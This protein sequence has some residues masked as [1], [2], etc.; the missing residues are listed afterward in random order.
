MENTPLN[1]L[2]SKNL[3]PSYY[4]DFQ[5]IGEK[6]RISCCKNW[7]ITFDKK[8]YLSLKKLKRSPELS[9]LMD[10]AMR[11]LR[12][13]DI[14][15]IHYAE[16]EL[17]DGICPL[18]A[19]S[20]LCNLQLEKGHK[21]LPE[22]C[23]IFPR[24]ERYYHSGYMQQS[25]SPACEAV[26][27]LLWNLPDGIEFR[28]SP[29][30]AD[31]IRN[32]SDQNPSPM[33]SHAYDIQSLC[34]D[35]LQDRRLPLPQRI[36]LM[37]ARLQELTKENTDIPAW[38]S[39]TRAI[40]S[41]SNV[42][43]QYK[44]LTVNDRSKIL[45]VSSCCKTLILIMNTESAFKNHFI[46]ILKSLNPDETENIS[47]NMSMYSQAESAFNEAF[48]NKEYFFENLTVSLMFH[49]KMP[50]LNSPEE[51]WKSYVNFCNLYSLYRFVSVLSA[52]TRLPPLPGESEDTAP[53][54]GS[55]EALFQTTVMISRS[56]IH[57]Q[58]RSADLRDDFFKNESSSLAHMAILVSG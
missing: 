39:K 8:D 51:L 46:S 37:G 26:L 50:N 45:R 55:R 56:M 53:E 3:R 58:Q 12:R 28:T 15:K 30:S 38:I 1:I 22:V 47:F 27:D 36:I 32:L 16:F 49:I 25:L 19:E 33:L 48:G 43:T 13:G 23:R 14:A 29:L 41:D 57:N 4:D 34:I 42:I 11:R 35:I 20:G 7:N 18:L 44:N 6:C 17:S 9:E 40:L 52:I 31:A 24:L 2:I 10:H 21:A 5:C 54:P